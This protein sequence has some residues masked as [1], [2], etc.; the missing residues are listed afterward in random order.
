MNAQKLCTNCRR[1]VDA[2]VRFCPYCGQ[3]A[4][5]E[6]PTVPTPQLPA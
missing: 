1:A 3:E 2:G 6:L 4:F 5:Q